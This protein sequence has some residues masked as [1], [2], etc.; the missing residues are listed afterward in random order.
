MKNFWKV[1]M[2]GIIMLAALFTCTTKEQ[3]SAKTIKSAKSYVLSKSYKKAT[4]YS[5]ST[6]VEIK[7]RQH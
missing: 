6:Y 3:A 7:K 1:T 4:Y 2:I 5:S